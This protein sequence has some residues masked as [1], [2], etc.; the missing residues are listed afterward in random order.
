MG[1][2]KR[3]EFTYQ[4]PKCIIKLIIIWYWGKGRQNDHQIRIKDSKWK[5]LTNMEI[6]T[7]TVAL[8]VPRKRMDFS[9]RDS[10]TMGMKTFMET[11]NWTPYFSF[12]KISPQCIKFLNMEVQTMKFSSEEAYRRK[13]LWPW[14]RYRFSNHD[15]KHERQRKKIMTTLHL[16][17]SVHQNVP[18]G[19]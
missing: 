9:V 19:G 11:W 1:Q 3:K 7:I 2:K 6:V 17:S 18:Y 5:M 12:Y 15:T 4:T 14:D 13:S 16:R 8:W 10:R